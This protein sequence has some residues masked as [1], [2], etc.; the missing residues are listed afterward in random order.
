MDP[1]KNIL[2]IRRDRHSRNNIGNLV[3]RHGTPFNKAKWFEVV[4]KKT[5]KQLE[6]L[7]A[8]DKDDAFNEFKRRKPHIKGTITIYPVKWTKGGK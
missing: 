4:D 7:T 1:V 2:G 6:V 5:G 3:D 8:K